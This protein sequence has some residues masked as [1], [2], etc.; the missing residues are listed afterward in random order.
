MKASLPS[1]H[2]KPYPSLG[3]AFPK[4]SWREPLYRLYSTFAI[5][6]FN[7]T[8]YYGA[9]YACAPR[10]EPESSGLHISLNSCSTDYTLKMHKK[11]SQRPEIQ[12]LPPVLARYAC[13]YVLRL[14]LE[15]TLRISAYA[16]PMHVSCI[17]QYGSTVYNYSIKPIFN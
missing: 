4:R 13:I 17:P 7:V 2:D 1:L 15:A 3:L 11:R 8:F 5:A 16:G 14:L 10:L 12:K 6:I 9:S